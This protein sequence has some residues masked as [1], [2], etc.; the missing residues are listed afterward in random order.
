MRAGNGGA[1]AMFLL[2]ASECFG[3]VASAQRDGLWPLRLLQRV[4]VRL[5][6]GVVLR[7]GHD[8]LG[9]KACPDGASRRA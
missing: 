6:D 8:V 2:F 1:P 3:S 9:R 5:R 7:E 4:D